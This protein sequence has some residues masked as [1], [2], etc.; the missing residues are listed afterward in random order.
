MRLFVLILIFLTGCAAPPYR[1]FNHNDEQD[2]VCRE[3]F[4]GRLGYC[5]QRGSKPI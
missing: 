2:D 4:G 1:E 5:D 3:S